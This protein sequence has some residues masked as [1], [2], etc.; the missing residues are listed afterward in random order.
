MAYFYA[1][2]KTSLKRELK[3]KGICFKLIGLCSPRF[4]V[5]GRHRYFVSIGGQKNGRL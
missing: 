2:N 3:H 4:D 5:E 1:V